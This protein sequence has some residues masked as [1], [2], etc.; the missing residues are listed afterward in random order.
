[1]FSDDFTGIT[2]SSVPGFIAALGAEAHRLMSVV[3]PNQV[4]K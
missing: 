1:M 3:L 2:L 4:G